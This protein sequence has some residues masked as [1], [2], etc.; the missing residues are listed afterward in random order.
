ML[1]ENKHVFDIKHSGQVTGREYEGQFTCVCI[2]TMG[3]KHQLEIE[4]TRLLAD[5]QNP[6][7]NLA[8]MALILANLRTRIIDAPDW[9]KESNGGAKIMDEDVVLALFNKVLEAEEIWRQKLQEKAG[10]LQTESK[11]EQKDG[12]PKASQ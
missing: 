3:Q 12:Q 11:A 9:W 4:R 5:F 7:E 1:P 6:T 10:G 2:L 8:G